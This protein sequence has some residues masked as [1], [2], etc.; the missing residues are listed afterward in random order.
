[1]GDLI[2]LPVRK[3]E[4]WNV[5]PG[6]TNC[7]GGRESCGTCTR[8]CFHA[9]HSFPA[10]SAHTDHD[11]NDENWTLYK[12]EAAQWPPKEKCDETD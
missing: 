8:P 11:K 10:C 7:R 6:Q 4:P 3:L 9:G 1:M 2:E 12:E 5:L